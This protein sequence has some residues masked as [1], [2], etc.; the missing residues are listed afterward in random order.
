MSKS[1]IQNW[2]YMKN[3]LI[4]LLKDKYD[5]SLFIGFVID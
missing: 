5:G 3:Y 1:D 4:L 2:Y